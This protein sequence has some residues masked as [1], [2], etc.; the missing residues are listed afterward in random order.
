M[1]RINMK[2]GTLRRNFILKRRKNVA[3]PIQVLNCQDNEKKN[4][5]TPGQIPSL[6]NFR[7]K[8]DSSFLYIWDDA[9]DVR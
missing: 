6:E 4:L 1:Q 3:Y 7:K 2:E 5:A 8:S 9:H